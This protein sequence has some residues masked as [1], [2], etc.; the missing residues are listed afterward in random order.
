MVSIKRSLQLAGLDSFGETSRKKQC[1]TSGGFPDDDKARVEAV[2]AA[3]K[4]G[5]LSEVAQ[6]AQGILTSKKKVRSRVF[7]YIREKLQEVASTL[8][9][10][11]ARARQAWID[12]EAQLRQLAAAATDAQEDEVRLT[13]AK[14]AELR[15][16]KEAEKRKRSCEE[17]LRELRDTLK[18]HTEKKAKLDQELEDTD[19][20]RKLRNLIENGRDLQ[21]FKEELQCVHHELIAKKADQ[22]LFDQPVLKTLLKTPAERKGFEIKVVD[23]LNREYL[24]P[25]KSKVRDMIKEHEKTALN[26]ETEMLDKEQDLQRADKAIEDSFQ[27]LAVAREKMEAQTHTVCEGKNKF[28][29]KRRNLEGMYRSFENAK[30]EE[31]EFGEINGIIEFLAG[32]QVVVER[33]SPARTTSTAQPESPT[34]PRS[35]ASSSTSSSPVHVVQDLDK[36]TQQEGLMTDDISEE[37]DIVL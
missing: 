11:T 14:D 32:Q 31:N 30:D 6:V 29:A 28:A 13:E 16:L 37:Q 25:R 35:Y 36:D 27:E 1:T 9:G 8:A 34:S 33:P 5:P 20:E 24:E 3:V 10:Q 22:S 7:G 17:A 2:L 21:D 4:A 23:Y 26:L 18:I 15:E 12:E 19:F